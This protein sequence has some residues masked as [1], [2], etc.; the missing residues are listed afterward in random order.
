MNHSLSEFRDIV[1]LLFRV[2]RN[3]AY[4]SH[5]LN[6]LV[7]KI[8]D[9]LASAEESTPVY[10]PIHEPRSSM[11][12]QDTSTPPTLVIHPDQDVGEIV[13]NVVVT[14]EEPD[15]RNLV[16]N[17]PAVVKA[18]KMETAA[19]TPTPMVSPVTAALPGP[20]SLMTTTYKLDSDVAILKDLALD[21]SDSEV[22]ESED[23]G[24]VMI[25]DADIADDTDEE[26]DAEDEEV[27]DE[28]VEEA[29][30]EEETAEAEEEE[31]EEE[32][33]TE[34]AEEAEDEEAEEA[35]EDDDLELL[36]IKKQRYYWSPSSTRIYEFLEEGYG[37]CLGTYVDGKIIPKA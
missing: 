16:V 22:E 1:V 4:Q 3:D 28:E 24:E 30:E 5:D 2:V 36:K 23:E 14:K 18:V 11:E 20:P 29:E 7:N 19:P 8:H 35:E 10:L 21:E 17:L 37:D 26:P 6:M 31:A 32:E 25:E 34:E 9:V 15:F 33:E 12:F 27:E 13:P